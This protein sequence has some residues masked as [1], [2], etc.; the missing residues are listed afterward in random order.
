MHPAPTKEGK[1]CS[2]LR[3]RSDLNQVDKVNDFELVVCVF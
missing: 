1:T 2:S 3:I